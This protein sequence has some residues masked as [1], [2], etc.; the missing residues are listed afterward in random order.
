MRRRLIKSVRTARS[1]GYK[2]VSLYGLFEQETREKLKDK[3]GGTT[4]RVKG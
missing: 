3:L 1:S 2:D 4:Q